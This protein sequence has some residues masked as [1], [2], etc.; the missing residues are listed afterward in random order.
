ME[1]ISRQIHHDDIRGDGA[2]DD[3]FA[4]SHDSRDD[5]RGD[6]DDDDD[7]IR[8]RDENED[9]NEFDGFGGEWARFDLALARLAKVTRALKVRRLTFQ[10]VLERARGNLHACALWASVTGARKPALR[11]FVG[12]HGG[13]S[14]RTPSAEKSSG[15]TLE[16]RELVEVTRGV[17]TTSLLAH[18]PARGAAR[19]LALRFSSKTVNLVFGTEKERE[20]FAEAIGLAGVHVKSLIGC[21]GVDVAARRRAATAVMGLNRKDLDDPNCPNALPPSLCA[22]EYELDR[23]LAR[24]EC[25]VCAPRCDGRFCARQVD[26]VRVAAGTRRWLSAHSFI[27]RRWAVEERRVKVLAAVL[28]RLNAA[29]EEAARAKTR[30]IR[31]RS[32][33][34]HLGAR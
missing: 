8:T 23:A 16:L 19:C 34:V 7:G 3:Y 1:P 14:S 25:G 4:G 32:H 20:R 6:D 26:E 28:E 2:R 11:Y 33:R 9:E 31:R 18:A 24:G 12:H 5:S 15:K 21:D 17:S 27:A 10:P 22:A 30:P 29:R 13:I